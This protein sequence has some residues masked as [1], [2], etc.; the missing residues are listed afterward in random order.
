M[1]GLVQRINNGV[2]EPTV[3]DDENNSMDHEVGSVFRVNKLQDW[4]I[5]YA[6]IYDVCIDVLDQ[7]SKM[8]NWRSAAV[9]L[10]IY[11]VRQAQWIEGK[12]E[13]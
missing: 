11:E 7:E 3:L 10:E 1:A 9:V 12:P 2:G 8:E 6:F 5:Q 4:Q 13:E